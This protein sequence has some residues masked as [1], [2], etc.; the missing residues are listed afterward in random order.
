ME[1]IRRQRVGLLYF[2]CDTNLAQLTG[3]TQEPSSKGHHGHISDLGPDLRVPFADAPNLRGVLQMLLNRR[4]S[5]YK[6]GIATDDLV[7]AAVISITNAM[8]DLTHLI[9]E[10]HDLLFEN[11]CGIAKVSDATK[12]EDGFNFLTSVRLCANT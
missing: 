11:I 9:H 1:T 5:C 2:D 12:S 3:V 10:D 7:R 8:H 4:T 6:E